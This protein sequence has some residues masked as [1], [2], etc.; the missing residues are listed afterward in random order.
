MTK[1]SNIVL[2]HMKYIDFVVGIF[3][4]FENKTDDLY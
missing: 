2:N 4:I 1:V 3:I